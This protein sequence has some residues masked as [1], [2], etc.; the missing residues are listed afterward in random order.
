MPDDGFLLCYVMCVLPDRLPAW[1]RFL[2]SVRLSYCV[3]R[4][5]RPSYLLDQSSPRPHRHT[6]VQGDAC[7]RKYFIF[8]S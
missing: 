8:N 5:C 6:M 1:G 7:T 4:H 3:V 2:S